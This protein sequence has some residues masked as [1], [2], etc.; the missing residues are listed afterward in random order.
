MNTKNLLKSVFLSLFL[1]F[2][3]TTFSK[4]IAAPRIYLNPGSI[5]ISNNSEFE[6]QLNIDV[7]NNNIFGTDVVLTYPGSDIELKSFASGG[8]FPSVSYAN[9]VSGRLEIHAFFPNLY[10]GKSGSGNLATLSF[11]AKKDS[12]TGSIDFTCSGSGNDT[13]ILNTIGEN[14]LS[15]GVLNQS[16][17]SYVSQGTDNETASISAMGDPNECGGTC[18]SNSNCQEGLFC[19]EGFCRNPACQVDANCV[20]PTAT[21]IPKPKVAI[22]E[23]PTPQAVE[24]SQYSPPSATEEVTTEEASISQPQNEK[25]AGFNT[26]S[27]LF[28][29]GILFS[30]IIAIVAIKNFI[31]KRKPPKTTP[32][33]TPPAVKPPL[34]T[35]SPPYNP[36]SA[37]NQQ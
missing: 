7:E 11:T 19:Y 3:S 18:G 4:A 5:T 17:L 26:R 37:Q 33:I 9:D 34:P 12:G 32:P 31:G 10:E 36:P 8:F 35:N 22:A 24:L 2:I 28:G 15:C 1:F 21:P 25:F 6:I 29:A 23:S 27:V 20:C 14:I 13:Q 30:L 16:N